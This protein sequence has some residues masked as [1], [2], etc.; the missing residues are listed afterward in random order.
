[1]E[2]PLKLLVTKEKKEKKAGTREQKL[3]LDNREHE[4]RKNAFRD[5]ENTRKILS[6][7]REHGYPLGTTI[8]FFQA[9]EAFHNTQL[10]D[11]YIF[12]FFNFYVTT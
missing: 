1:M 9:S 12:C 6:G 5:Q 10:I 4:N 7:T 11:F 3:C 8:D 2:V